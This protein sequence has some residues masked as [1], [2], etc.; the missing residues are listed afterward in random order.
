M[1]VKQSR[2]V[3]SLLPVVASLG[4]KK[5]TTHPVFTYNSAAV[6]GISK[7]NAPYQSDAFVTVSGVSFGFADYS[8][9][10]VFHTASETTIWTSDTSLSGV[11]APG[12][13]E[14]VATTVSVGAHSLDG[15]G[16]AG[17]LVCFQYNALTNAWS[18]D[19]VAVS[20]MSP[21]NGGSSGG[22]PLTVHGQH[23]ARTDHSAEVRLGGT[24]CEFTVWQS[25]SAMLCSS[26][27]GELNQRFLAADP[28]A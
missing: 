9:R 3:S 6:A 22:A 8:A 27:P 15:L 18:Y 4:I 12:M 1:H 14:A 11:P 17:C 2:G 20:S 24:G 13:M 7:Q 10:I 16:F 25:I 28:S 26:P 23:F 21:P 5:Y 19:S